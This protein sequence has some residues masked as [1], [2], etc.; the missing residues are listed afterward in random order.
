MLGRG[1]N[2]KPSSRLVGGR[3]PHSPHRH[4][5]SV[6]SAISSASSASIP[7][8]RTV[9][10]PEVRRVVNTAREQEVLGLQLGLPDP[11]LY[12]VARGRCDLELHRSLRLL[13]HDDGTRS[14]LIAMADVA[15]LEFHK[16]AAAQLAV[17]SEIKKCELADP[18]LHL[19]TNSERP[20]VLE[21]ERRLLADAARTPGT[22]RS[23]SAT[24][25]CK[26]YSR[27]TASSLART[28][29]G[30]RPRSRT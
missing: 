13:L 28:T 11:L 15:D 21:L 2:T 17:D 16:I 8:Y 5:T 4:H 24:S 27:S 19:Q 12:R 14:D 30:R 23:S 7:R 1:R 22:S 29:S 25:T 18:V 6:C 20:D 26:W 9:L 3:R 10:S